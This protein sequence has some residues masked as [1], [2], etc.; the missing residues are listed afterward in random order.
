MNVKRVL[1]VVALILAAASTILAWPTLP[2][3]VMLICLG[4]L[5]T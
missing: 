3:A 4:L 1:F 5:I 2:I